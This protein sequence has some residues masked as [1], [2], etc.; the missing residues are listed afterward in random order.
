MAG[1]RH[2][3][4]S[5]PGVEGTVESC[6]YTCSHGIMPG[7]AMLACHP[8]GLPAM[9]G[10]LVITDGVGTVR[11][12]ACRVVD[13]TVRQD[14]QGTRLT[15]SIQDRRW[16]WSGGRIDGCY[17]QLDPRGKL[18]P[19]TVRAPK[20]LALL[21]LQ[22]MGEPR[23][24]I[25]ALPPGLSSGEA[26]AAVGNRI[27]QAGELLPATGVNPP[28]NWYAIPPSQALQ[29][30]AEMFGCRVVYDP[31]TD[32]VIVAKVGV[33][34]DLPAG[35]LSSQG[36]SLRPP[37]APSAVQVVGS[38][39]LYQGR[40]WLQPVGE[41]WDGSYVPID[42]LS[43]SPARR[44]PATQQWAV[45]ITY[46]LVDL[47]VGYEIIAGATGTDD[48]LSGISF[49]RSPLAMETADDI[50]LALATQVN[51]SNE[52]LI[53]GNLT[54]TAAGPVVTITGVKPGYAFKVAARMKY[55]FTADNTI[56]AELARVAVAPLRHRWAESVPGAFDDAQAT[57]RLT[58]SQA[59]ALAQ[60]TVF[61]LFQLT[62][63]DV[64]DRTSAGAPMKVPGYPGPIV[65]RQQV[66]LTG[67]QVDQVVPYSGDP[68]I[69]AANA[70]EVERYIRDLY[71]GYSR[72]KA[73]AVYGRVAHDVFD[74]SGL[75]HDRAGQNT[76]EGEIVPVPFHVEVFHQLV[77]FSS[78]VWKWAG[79]GTVGYPSLQLQT[80]V[81]VR[82]AA[83]NQ[84]SAFSLSRPL[85]GGNPLAPPRTEVHDDVQANV[86]STYDGEGNIASASLLE[87]DALVRAGHY[88]TGM[89]LRYAVGNG[90]AAEY[91][92][93][94]PVRMD[95]AVMQASWS[96]GPGGAA[97]RASRN[98][99]FSPYVPPYPARRRAE[100][101]PPPADGG[102]QQVALADEAEAKRVARLGR[103]RG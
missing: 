71:S 66:V 8:T 47:A 41:E 40:F 54:A 26:L 74:A 20:E 102:P 57:D 82:D 67:E 4:A 88:L 101:M 89:T 100:A 36:P 39:T 35:S 16:R 44:E 28:I 43:Y 78:P 7:T 19:W 29:Q 10:D 96:V 94:V 15:L 17:N 69:L 11:L 95:G 33:G 24:D 2:G 80:G 60:K 31:L 56:V 38:P 72:G 70:E 79:D 27:L 62:G 9:L 52:P 92:G 90:Q 5:W 97:T 68:S 87:A 45:E 61:R 73:A 48:A 21:C 34:G 55:S 63:V 85:P 14:G 98:F 81:M 23:Y 103:A 3:T 93:I 32:S 13:Y 65:R 25:D 50:A 75:V 1:E 37:D 42:L 6:E 99:E 84:L 18:I 49:I 76:P 30:V 64:S 83:T 53:R 51:A 59:V 22:A 58:K 77:A 86:T 46:G 12:P 91:N